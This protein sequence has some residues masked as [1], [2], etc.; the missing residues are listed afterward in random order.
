MR[1]P[2]SPIRTIRRIGGDEFIVSP[3]RI[4]KYVEEIAHLAE[5]LIDCIKTPRIEVNC[6]PVDLGVSIGIGIFPDY[7]EDASALIL[8]ADTARASFW[9]D[10]LRSEYRLTVY[11]VHSK[12]LMYILTHV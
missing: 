3:R 9:R 10:H 6:T 5:R 11:C 1:E 12:H 2:W 7:G 4:R 8:S